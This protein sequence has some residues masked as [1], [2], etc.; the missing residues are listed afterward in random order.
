MKF[1][2]APKKFWP[3]CTN[4]KNEKVLFF[5][6]KNSLVEIFQQMLGQIFMTPESTVHVKTS[7]WQQQKE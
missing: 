1:G 4:E 3:F 6:K 2:L 7:N 5:T